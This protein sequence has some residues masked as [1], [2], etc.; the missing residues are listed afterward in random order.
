MNEFSKFVDEKQPRFFNIGYKNN[1]MFKTFKKFTKSP[2]LIV[3]LRNTAILFVKI[4]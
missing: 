4:F 1:E 3:V 2:I